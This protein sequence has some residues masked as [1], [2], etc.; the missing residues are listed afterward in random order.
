NPWDHEIFSAI[1]RPFRR[2]PSQRVHFLPHTS[3]DP[4]ALLG[5]ARAQVA[6]V[7]P[8]Q[9]VQDIRTY[10]KTMDH[11]L[12]G[13][14][15]VASMMAVF[16]VIALLLSAAGVYGVMACSVAERAREIGLRMA[17]GAQDRDVVW[18]VG[19]WGVLLTAGGL[20]LR[21]TGRVRARRTIEESG[22]RR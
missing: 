19:R 8:D 3:G 6:P 7:D 11:A 4:L 20:A 16:G 2:A 9:P 21:H 15:Y 10:R 5:A 18:M 14:V 17:L 13:L 1:Y 12:V 22:V